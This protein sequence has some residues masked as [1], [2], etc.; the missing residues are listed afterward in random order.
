MQIDTLI[1]GF[2]PLVGITG[3]K[4]RELKS[5][6]YYKEL[7]TEFDLGTVH[8]STNKN[9]QEKI[10]QAN[11]LIII[12]FGGEYFAEEVKRYKNDALI[13]VAE[14]TG[15]IFY[16]KADAEE[17]KEKNRRIL[18]EASE[19]VQKTREGGEKEVEAIRKY[20][21]MSYNDL[22][23]MITKALISDNE[24]LKKQAWDLL[25]GEGER[26]SNFV[27]MRLQVMAEVWEHS[28]GKTL[29]ELMCMSMEK[30]IDQATARKM[31]NFTDADG[32]EYHQ[33]MFLDSLGGDTNHIRRLPFAT[34]DQNR[35][36][37]ENLLEKN[38]IPTNYLRVQ[39]EANSLR[40]Q[41]DD[42]LASDCIKV[43]RVLEEWKKDQTKSKEELGVV[44]WEKGD[45]PEDPLTE[46][47]I[48]SMKRFLKKY[49]EDNFVSLFGELS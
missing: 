29:E 45:S 21:S 16:R 14:D 34:K 27:W 11:P 47:E 9:W 25:F 15:S 41:W 12:I 23:K 30:H 39:V 22:Y 24:D 8:Y 26:H 36:S 17:K 13:Y 4:P 40:K 1:I 20:T 43:K 10:D 32:L 38:E 28:E 2:I 49:D 6:S 46:R 7:L 37:Y 33:Y 42:Y 3:Q 35:Y 31:D 44:P 48:A 19:M 18:I 5:D